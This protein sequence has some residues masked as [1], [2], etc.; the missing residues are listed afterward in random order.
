[1]EQMVTLLLCLLVGAISFT[2]VD[3]SK[4]SRRPLTTA[5]LAD[6]VIATWL[7]EVFYYSA[8]SDW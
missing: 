2:S 1:M 3:L 6:P 4:P 5:L 8:Q 7:Q